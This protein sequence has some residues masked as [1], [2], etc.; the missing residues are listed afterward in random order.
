[1]SL[2]S[3]S[4]EILE[5]IASYLDIPSALSFIQVSRHVNAVFKK[6]K[7]FWTLVAKYIGLEVKNGD[8]VDVI[9]G[10]FINWKSGTLHEITKL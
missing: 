10:R 1:M 7:R 4:A 6:N 3:V 2:V 5:D 9:K 8:S